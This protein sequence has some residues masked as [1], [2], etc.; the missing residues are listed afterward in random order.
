[1]V[2]KVQNSRIHMDG[3]KRLTLLRICAQ[4]NEGKCNH[5]EKWMEQI[6]KKNNRRHSHVSKENKRCGEL[7]QEVR[8]VQMLTSACNMSEAVLL[9]W[10]TVTLCGTKKLA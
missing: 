3:T 9:R 1:M 2:A 6:R 10:I 4:G 8:L 5:K 7:H